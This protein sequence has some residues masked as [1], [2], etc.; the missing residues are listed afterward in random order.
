LFS[1]VGQEARFEIL[2]VPRWALLFGASLGALF[3]GLSVMYVPPLRGPRV[4]IAAAVILLASV[5]LWP[6]QALLLAQA[7]SFGVCLAVFSFVLRRILTW[8]DA[9]DVSPSGRVPSLIERSSQRLPFRSADEAKAAT[10]TASI[11]VEVADDGSGV[12]VRG[13]DHSDQG[14]A[15]RTRAEP[16]VGASSASRKN[17]LT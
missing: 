13:A 10:T 16:A 8:S 17:Q 12:S 15:G 2:A 9:R 14:E 7:A 1:T 4:L 5:A 11:A 6:E 3:V